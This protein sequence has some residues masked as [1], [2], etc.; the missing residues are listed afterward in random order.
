MVDGVEPVA[1]RVR[2]VEA[3]HGRAAVAE[4]AQPPPD[5]GHR[6]RLRR[7]SR[8]FAHH[9]GPLPAGPPVHQLR[10][11][12]RGAVPGGVDRSGALAAVVRPLPPVPA[13]V[14][15]ADPASGMLARPLDARRRIGRPRVPAGVSLGHARP[16]CRGGASVP[17]AGARAGIPV[18]PS[19]RVLG[20]RR[21]DGDAISQR[22]L[23]A[24][25]GIGEGGTAL[26]ASRRGLGAGRVDS[27]VTTVLRAV[28]FQHDEPRFRRAAAGRGRDAQR[29]A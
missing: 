27:G 18:R 4:L 20:V 12:R 23:P 3:D 11:R 7:T 29:R 8:P 25:A 19:P 1:G 13:G 26:P 6:R 28:D 14:D 2:A 10:G 15:V 16:F 9:G 21:V 5:I 22:A 17:A 24:D